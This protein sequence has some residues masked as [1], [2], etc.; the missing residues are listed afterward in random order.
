[1]A[2]TS[3]AWASL[4]DEEGLP[5]WCNVALKVFAG[6]VQSW[7]YVNASMSTTH[8]DKV[9]VAV[10]GPV[11]NLH[12]MQHGVGREVQSTLCLRGRLHMHLHHAFK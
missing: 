4:P 11:I 12:V 2:A 1:M 6:A 5:S 10:K 9:T 8:R 3:V 7:M